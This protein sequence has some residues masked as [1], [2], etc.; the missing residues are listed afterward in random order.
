MI[1]LGEIAVLSVCY[2]KQSD[3][4]WIWH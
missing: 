4:Y 2:D 3:Q 1:L